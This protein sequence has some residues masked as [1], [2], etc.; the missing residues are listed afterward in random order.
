MFYQV[1]LILTVSSHPAFLHIVESIFA[2]FPD[3]NQRPQQYQSLEFLTGACQRLLL[4][5][6]VTDD[7]PVT[8]KHLA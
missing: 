8:L 3:G 1:D 7:F 4:Y 2:L 6:A 5:P